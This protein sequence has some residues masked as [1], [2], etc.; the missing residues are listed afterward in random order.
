MIVSLFE[1]FRSRI[2]QEQADDLLEYIS[3]FTHLSSQSFSD[4]R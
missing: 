1:I 3:E 2:T 4:L